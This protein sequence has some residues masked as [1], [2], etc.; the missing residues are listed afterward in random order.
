MVQYYD[1][2]QVL[3]KAAPTAPLQAATDTVTGL[4]SAYVRIFV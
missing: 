1:P 2:L 3:G 4:L